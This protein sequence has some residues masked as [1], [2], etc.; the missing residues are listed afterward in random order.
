MES[1]TGNRIVYRLCDET[2]WPTSLNAVVRFVSKSRELKTQLVG[3][4]REKNMF[5]AKHGLLYDYFALPFS[6]MK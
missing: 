1:L 3:E 6:C 5:S 2:L 4:N